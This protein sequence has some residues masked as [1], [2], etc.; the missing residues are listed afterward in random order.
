MIE[1]WIL[2]QK[3][4]ILRL[5]GDNME[6]LQLT[7][8][9]KMFGLR[10]LCNEFAESINK[11]LDWKHWHKAVGGLVDNKIAECWVL[12]DDKEYIGMLVWSY[13]PCLVTQELSATEICFYTSEKARGHGMKLLNKMIEVC[14]EKKVINVNMAHFA[15]NERIGTMYNR[16]NFIKSEISYTL[17][18]GE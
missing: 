14:K 5:L 9:Q 10:G 3:F 11:N 4:K 6:L 13:F 16:M 1:A 15:G 8:K 17:R 2:Y 12:N 18:L 7:S